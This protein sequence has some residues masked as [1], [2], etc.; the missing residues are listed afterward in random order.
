MII[1]LNLLLGHS[2]CSHVAFSLTPRNGIFVPTSAIHAA[3]PRPW[4]QLWLP[5]PPLFHRW[6]PHSWAVSSYRPK[7]RSLPPPDAAGERR[8]SPKRAWPHARGRRASPA[9]PPPE[10]AG[11][12]GGRKDGPLPSSSLLPTEGR[13]SELGAAAIR[14]RIWRARRRRHRRPPGRGEGEACAQRRRRGRG[15]EGAEGGGR[16]EY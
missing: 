12:K 14:G 11:E 4:S 1:L 13:S 10:L 16:R 2:Q 5:V 3:C 6:G 7:P 9:R 8:A 15:G